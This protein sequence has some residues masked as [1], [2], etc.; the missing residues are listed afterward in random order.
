MNKINS[1]NLGLTS[2]V[3]LCSGACLLLY[4]V[5]FMDI[6]VIGIPI[7]INIVFNDTYNEIYIYIYILNM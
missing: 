3:I 7:Y 6:N 1:N 2:N 4:V 5:R